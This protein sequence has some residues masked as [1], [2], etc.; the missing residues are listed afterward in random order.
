MNQE[1][2]TMQKIDFDQTYVVSGEIS[3]R[4]IEGQILLLRPDDHCLYT[5]NG[6]G[7]FIWIEILK[8]KPVSMIAKNL[9]KSFNISEEKACKDVLKFV[10]DLEEK[11][12]IVKERKK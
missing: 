11:K 8:R 12:I 7:K 1:R 6:T 10:R 4:E 9:A 2:C 5:V 3:H